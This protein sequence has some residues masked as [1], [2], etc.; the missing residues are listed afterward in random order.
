MMNQ[1]LKCQDTE[2]ARVV[3]TKCRNKNMKNMSKK[4][5][6]KQSKW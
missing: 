1:N 4:R 6:I 5:A 3:D 2:R